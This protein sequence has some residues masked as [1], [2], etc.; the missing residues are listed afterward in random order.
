MVARLAL[1]LGYDGSP[2]LLF[3]L[4]C[5][6]MM[7]YAPK[8]I[9]DD[10]EHHDANIRCEDYVVGGTVGCTIAAQVEIFF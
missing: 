4:C 5:R 6:H 2:M 1:S 10:R 7:T 9:G 8:D 3:P